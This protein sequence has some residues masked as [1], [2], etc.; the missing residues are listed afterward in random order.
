MYDILG[1]PKRG[2]KDGEAYT[3]SFWAKAGRGRTITAEVAVEG[4]D[5]HDVGL[6]SVRSF[7]EQWH[8]NSLAFTASKTIANANCAG[9]FLKASVGTIDFTHIELHP[10][11]E[12]VK[13]NGM[14]EDPL[15]ALNEESFQF[16]ETLQIPVSY[17][18]MAVM[19]AGVY[20]AAGD[21][22]FRGY[23]MKSSDYGFARFQEVLI[24]KPLVIIVTH[25][26]QKA[27]FTK[28]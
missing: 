11:L 17:K 16:V 18:G 15:I 13:K 7:T 10:G 25:S 24:G 28:L 4:E 1:Q 9:F 26:G 6:R 2:L 23:M 8:R 20:L 14:I 22:D 3:F 12:N 21:R 19:Q 5:Y 27:A